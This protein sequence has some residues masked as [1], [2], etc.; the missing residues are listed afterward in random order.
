MV[1]AAPG[2]QPVFGT[3][4]LA[5]GIPTSAEPFSFDMATSAVA[6]FGVLSAKAKGEPLPSGV[7]Y[8]SSGNFTTDASSVLNGGSIATFGGHKGLGLSLCVELLAGVLSGSAVLGQCPSKKEAK[9]WGHC[10]IA[11]NP[12][13]LVDDYPQ[14]V[15][16]VIETVRQSAPDG[17]NVVRIPGQRSIQTA[18]LRR[19]SGT[20]PIPIKIWES[21]VNTSKNGLPS[22][23]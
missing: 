23:S 2:A 18:K 7:A 17:N 1:S 3:N 12:N 13:L 8:D 11:I 10:F 4:P 15:T 21:I 19:E 5:V 22:S 6:L 16:S 14:K 20:M 9:S